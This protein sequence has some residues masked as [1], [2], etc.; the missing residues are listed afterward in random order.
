MRAATVRAAHCPVPA[1]CGLPPGPRG[2]A[3]TEGEAQST[4]PGV[5]VAAQTQED[6]RTCVT[7]ASLEG[8]GPRGGDTWVGPGARV[9]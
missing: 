7:T 8:R 4:G 9:Y 6:R 1:G 3:A 2:P 5:Q